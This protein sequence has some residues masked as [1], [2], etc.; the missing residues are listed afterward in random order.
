MPFYVFLGGVF[1]IQIALANKGVIV[2]RHSV[3]L[4]GTD[5]SD[6]I[7]YHR[8]TATL[9]NPVSIHRYGPPF[10]L[11]APVSRLGRRFIDWPT[12][13]LA[14]GYAPRLPLRS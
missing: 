10:V 11:H 4:L 3:P 9:G 5:Y 8:L 14:L 1:D 6:R 13:Q 7:A 12:S 2:T